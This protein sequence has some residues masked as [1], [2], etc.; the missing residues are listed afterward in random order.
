MNN[1]P[2]L[3]IPMAGRGQRF[4]DMG[5]N[6]PKPLIMAGDKS[7]IDWS[8]N[9]IDANEYNLIFVVRQEHINNFSI[10]QILKNKYGNEI[11]IV[12]A[13]KITAGSVSSCL[14]AKCYINNDTPLIIYTLDVYFEPKFHF[15]DIDP[16]LDGLILTFKSNNPAYSYVKVDNSG[17]VTETAEKSVISNNASAGIYCFRKGNLFVHYAERMIKED[18]RT[19]NEFYICPLYNL[20]IYS[21]LYN[22]KTMNVEKMYII[23]TPE[24]LNFFNKNIFKKFGKN[25]PIAICGDHSGF[26]LKESVLKILKERNVEYIDFGTYINKDCDYNDYIISATNHINDGICDYGMAFCRS[27]QGVNISAN[28]IKGIRSALIFDEYTAEYSIRHNCANFFSI[29]SKYV[30]EELLNKMVDQLLT[31]SFDGGRHM[32]RIQKI[33][34]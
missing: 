17:L 31:H 5:Y 21:G 29:P 11:T 10:D 19:N 3:L 20:F 1:K 8:F 14:L 15:K 7:I 13:D 30:N 33:E 27:G 28:K 16:N 34:K 22:I 18:L 6:I 2:N 25:K 32:N 9:S 24:E 12:V 4:V 26:E 23:G